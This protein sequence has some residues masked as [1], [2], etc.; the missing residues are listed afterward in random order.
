MVINNHCF[1]VFFTTHTQV[2]SGNDH[3][4]IYY[5]GGPQN[6]P[7]SGPKYSYREWNETDFQVDFTPPIGA[8]PGAPPRPP[9]RGGSKYPKR[10]VFRILCGGGP[11]TRT[12]CFAE[13]ILGNARRPGWSSK[14]FPFCVALADATTAWETAEFRSPKTPNFITT[15]FFSRPLC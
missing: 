5:R 2:P 3:S 4:Y 6:T 11:R 15:F 13:A 12:V 1:F 9:P 14:G 7:F 8:P 10:G